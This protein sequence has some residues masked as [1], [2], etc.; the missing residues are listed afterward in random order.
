MYIGIGLPLIF[1]SITTAS[2]DGI[3]PDKTDQASALINVARNVGSSIG[4]SLALNVLAYRQQFHQSRLV[5]HIVPSSIQYRETLQRTTGYFATHASSPGD[6]Q[7]QAFAWIGRQVQMQASL[8]AYIDVF[9]V[10]M[11]ISASAVPLALILREVKPRPGM[12][13]GH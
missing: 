8:L 3:P 1:I 12:P 6:A 2:Y 5:E 11:L 9:W 10:L 4:I 7:H 13:P